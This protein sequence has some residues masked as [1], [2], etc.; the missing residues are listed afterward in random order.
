MFQSPSHAPVILSVAATTNIRKAAECHGQ[1]A[2]GRNP[3]VQ[4]FAVTER[5]MAEERP[6]RALH[7]V[8][9]PA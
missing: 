3:A 4:H 1:Q 7:V 2:G 8:G 5:E 9:K 6:T